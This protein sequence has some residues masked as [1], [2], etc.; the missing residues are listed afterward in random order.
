MMKSPEGKTPGT[1]DIVRKIQ[2]A[3]AKKN[4]IIRELT[5][6]ENTLT[7]ALEDAKKELVRAKEIA[8]SHDQL[9]ETLGNILSEDASQSEPEARG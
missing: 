1:D 2:E 5:E 6:R 3:L 4:Q 8:R 7:K 9:I